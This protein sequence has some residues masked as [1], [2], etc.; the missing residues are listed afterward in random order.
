MTADFRIMQFPWRDFLDHL[1]FRQQ[2]MV[3]M[4]KIAVLLRIDTAARGIK[5]ITSSALSATNDFS[6][7]DINFFPLYSSEGPV[8]QKIYLIW[9]KELYLTG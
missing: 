8:I 5:F 1:H 2:I 4:N 6:Q 9:N 7:K 3:R